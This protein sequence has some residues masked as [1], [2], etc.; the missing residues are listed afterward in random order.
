MPTT[1]QDLLGRLLNKEQ[2]VEA[3]K[4]VRVYDIINHSAHVSYPWVG[5]NSPHPAR[6]LMAARTCLL[7]SSLARL[8]RPPSTTQVAG[9]MHRVATL[10]APN[11]LA[12]CVASTTTSRIAI[13]ASSK[14]F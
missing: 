10:V 5:D 12:K 1:P 3:R 8:P 6:L 2:R 9:P 4:A 13:A 7:P 11:S 14:I